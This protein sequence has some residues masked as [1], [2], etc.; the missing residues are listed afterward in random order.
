MQVK[1]ILKAIA[2]IVAWFGPLGW[3]IYSNITSEKASQSSTSIVAQ[4]DTEILKKQEIG[5]Q[6][7]PLPQNDLMLNIVANPTFSLEDFVVVGINKNN[8]SL[9]DIQIYRDDP[10]IRSV[11]T[12]EFGN[13]NEMRLQSLYHKAM[14]W[15]SR[16]QKDNVQSDVEPSFHRDNIF[17]PSEQRRKGHDYE[18]LINAN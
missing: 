8:V 14:E 18:E 5:Y 7:S 10:Y 1:T 15:L 12:D 11:F 6:D 9:K 3:V 2:Y 4:S 16:L 17:A 13:L